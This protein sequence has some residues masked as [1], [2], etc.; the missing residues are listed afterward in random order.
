MKY[1]HYKVWA[2]NQIHLVSEDRG[3]DRE[4]EM[5][6]LKESFIRQLAEDKIEIKTEIVKEY[7]GDE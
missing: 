5:Q 7:G 3:Q 6:Q 1:I 4:A 2:P